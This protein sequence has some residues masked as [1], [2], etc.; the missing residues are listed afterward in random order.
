MAITQVITTLPDAPD[1]ATMTQDEFDDAAAAFVL[2]QKEMVPE[3][4]TWADE[5]NAIAATAVG[6]VATAIGAADA[7][8]PVAA[9]KFAF[10]KDADGSLKSITFANLL[11]AP[12]DIGGTTPAA[13]TGTLIKAAVGANIASAAT[14]DLTVAT[15]NTV[16]I[17]GTTGIS[18]WTM[19]AGQVMDIIFDG[20]LTL[21]HHA[22]TNNLPGAADIYTAAGDRARLFYDGTTAYMLSHEYADGSGYAESVV[23][24]GSAVSLTTGVAANITSLSLPAGKWKVWGVVALISSGNVGTAWIGGISDTSAVIDAVARARFQNTSG[25]AIGAHHLTVP[26]RRFELSSPTTV[27]LTG[28][29]TFASGSGSGYGGIYAERMD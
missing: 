15:G 23:P 27:Y 16:H 18:A 6:D 25:S 10:R 24:A 3:I 12:G 20:A 17:T 29:L 28:L 4:N 19:A 22:T 14:V 5:V 8:T 11:A 13:I 2:A 26:A 1:P 9:D 7:D 21:T